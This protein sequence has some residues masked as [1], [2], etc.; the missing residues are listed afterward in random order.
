MLLFG[1]LLASLCPSLSKVE[2][3]GRRPFG[4]K[5]GAVVAISDA[6]LD[7][8][9]LA[10]NSVGRSVELPGEIA[11]DVSIVS[12][13]DGLGSGIF[14]PFPIWAPP[15]RSDVSSPPAE[16]LASMESANQLASQAAVPKVARTRSAAPSERGELCELEAL[17][18][19]SVL[20][21]L[22]AVTHGSTPIDG[23]GFVAWSV[24]DS[25]YSD[26]IPE[27]SAMMKRTEVQ[28]EEHGRTLLFVCTDRETVSVA[29]AA[30]QHAVFY[31]A[32]N[33]TTR[34]A[35]PKF[36]FAAQLASLGI[37][38]I[39]VEMDIWFLFSPLPLL[40]E[41]R[42]AATPRE[43]QVDIQFP[44][45][46]M[47]PQQINIGFYDVAANNRTAAFFYALYNTLFQVSI[48][49]QDIFNSCLFKSDEV[50]EESTSSLC[51]SGDL[52][53]RMFDPNVFVCK[54]PPLLLDRTVAAHVL[55]GTPL[56]SSFNKKVVAKELMIWEDF[57]GYY[58]SSTT[59]YL[60]LDGYITA[61][62]LDIPL[63]H[64]A[65]GVITML[66]ALAASTNRTLIMPMALNSASQVRIRF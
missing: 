13:Y 37:R 2:G 66:V 54:D 65:R 53:Y 8:Q 34:V 30:G 14:A 19:D 61:N 24:I 7:T 62:S 64:L 6:A 36:K 59:K 11:S 25:S 16:W 51:Y 28:D 12:L 1:L 22:V 45:H 33:E 55:T 56:T 38:G 26:M 5:Q 35:E 23:G 31:Q 57:S 42:G 9:A 52:S 4:R 20:K 39:F 18:F 10:R 63:S 3:D 32:L 21:R 48:F 58:S 60:A 17:D 40:N 50:Y 29:C 27:F 46:Q 15:A 43:F 41:A 47:L 49:D 44:S